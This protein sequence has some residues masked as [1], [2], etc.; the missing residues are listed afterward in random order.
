M[1]P[2]PF[3]SLPVDRIL[4]KSD[5]VLAT[6]DLYPVSDGH[7]LLVT[8][9]HCDTYFNTTDRERTALWQAVAR[10]KTQLDGEFKPDGFNVGF[11][12]GEA[13]GQTVM[14]VHIHIIPRYTGDAIDPS[15]GV[16]GVIA[17]K[18]KYGDP[19]PAAEPFACFPNIVGGEDEHF[20]PILRDA[21]NLAT[22]ADIIAAFVQPAGIAQ[23]LGDL[24]DALARGTRVRIVTGDYLNSTSPDALRELLRLQ[25]EH[26]ENLNSFFFEGGGSLSF[27][28]K[29]YIFL[30]GDNGIAY[31]GSS[32]LTRTALTTGVEWNLRAT[33]TRHSAEFKAVRDR[34]ERTLQLP[35]V[36]PLTR[37][38]IDLYSERARVPEGIDQSAEGPDPRSPPPPPHSLQMEALA[39]LR[40]LRDDG[41]QAGLVVMATGLGKTYL[42]ALDFKEIDGDRALFIAHRDEILTQAQDSWARLFPGRVMGRMVG[43]HKEPDAD[44]LFASVQ[45]LA[46]KANLHQFSPDH[47]DYI[48]VDEFHHA[49]ASTYRKILAH[50]EPRFLLGLT[51]TPDRMDGASIRDLCHNNLAYRA[52]LVRGINAGLLVPF[53]YYG[54][55]D[56]VNFQAIP[57]RGRWPTK[58]LTEAVATQERAA[59]A[60]REYRKHAPQGPRRTLAFC[61]SVAHADFMAEAFSSS[62]IRAVAVHSGTSSAPREASLRKLRK[63]E[64][65]VI[66]AVDIF[67][68]GLDVPD[69]NVVLMLRPTE[70]PVIF[71]QQLGRGLRQPKAS[72]KP[73]LTIV[74]FIG[75][76]RSFMI[77]PQALIALIGQDL[78]PAAA[79][80]AVR[81]QELELP[82]GC[83]VNIETDAID[84]LEKICRISKDDALVFEYQSLRNSHGRRP[85][86]SE[87]LATGVHMKP[88]KDRHGTWFEFVD[89]QGDLEPHEARVLARHRPWF[90]DLL[91]TNMTRSYKMVTLRGMLDRGRMRAGM[92]VKEIVQHS[93]RIMRDDLL[94]RRELEEVDRSPDSLN[95]LEKIWREMPLTKWTAG[96]STSRRW[97]DLKDDNFSY[98]E[99]VAAEDAETFDEMTAEMVDMRLA[100]HR[101]RLRGQVLDEVAPIR[102]RVSHA[103]GRPIL[104]LDRDRR[105]DTPE[106]GLDMPVI[107]DGESYLFGFRKVAVNTAVRDTGGPNELPTLMRSWYGPT[108]GRPGS[109][110]F[111]LLER[112]GHQWNL[113]PETPTKRNL[114]DTASMIPFPALPYYS[115]FGVACGAWQSQ[116]EPMKQAVPIRVVA[117]TPMDSKRH[118]VLRASGSSM[119]GGE[120]PITDGDLVLFEWLSPTSA[121]EIEDKACLLTAENADGESI[122]ALKVPV[123]SDSGWL[124]RSWNPEFDDQPLDSQTTVQPVARVVE[125]V[126]EA[127]G[128]TLWGKYDRESAA[129]LFGLKA[130]RSW[131]V[132]HRDV[133]V[134][135][136]EHSV[137]FVNLQKGPGVEAK[138]RYADRFLTP[139]EFQWESQASTTP[140]SRKGKNIIEHRTHDRHIH[141][142]CRYADK[143]KG[144]TQ[145]YVYCGS[146]QYL[147]HQGS[148]PVRVWFQLDHPLPDALWRLWSS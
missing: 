11:N 95:R 16:R 107:V 4:W 127:P 39:K 55:K 81:R 67:N 145:P 31:V 64:I 74:D 69:I 88:V 109:R 133:E 15:G 65:E 87:V 100:D 143:F 63:G 45:T 80:D 128:P 117:A 49:A 40:D 58:E 28:P 9:R 51:A 20:A 90:K 110:Q 41:G 76:H 60:M 119:D 99:D 38:L 123:R 148:E 113:S 56:E 75:N 36:K 73:F 46:R 136:T 2:C 62:G 118:F 84:M 139:E 22:E 37:D 77:K 116:E 120:T 21:L 130:D 115:E 25:S 44:L 61:C 101:N 7:T 111:V 91:T 6:R 5:L 108:A 13:S 32:N 112:H 141:L 103:G 96:K 137:L 144:K 72:H 66:C 126:E 12:V 24:R 82:P 1:P 30:A 98:A 146:V 131:Q 83:S 121:A 53:R 3:C 17:E 147:R 34:F 47:F 35:L 19:S 78:A 92:S 97:F 125:V 42:S 54:V 135:G 138:H 102:L 140:T 43:D 71:L 79:L 50:F 26:P 134:L 93:H 114:D 106:A 124:L 48:V 33:T 23:I 29:A 85:T 8:R 122:A 105:P 104:R 27:H 94:L 52:S 68:E 70:S 57:W 132:G 142:F 59:Q 89:S 18:Q 129:A 14:H 10:C 86:A